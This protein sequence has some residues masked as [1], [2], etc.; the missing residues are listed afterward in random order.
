MTEEVNIIT[1]LEMK[2]MAAMWRATWNGDYHKAETLGCSQ[3]ALGEVPG[4]GT[5]S[6]EGRGNFLRKRAK[7]SLHF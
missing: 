5:I 7:E 6:C 3:C 2:N 4:V 1:V